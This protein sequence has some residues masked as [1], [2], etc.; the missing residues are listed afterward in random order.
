MRR[1][2]C[3]CILLVV[4]MGCGKSIGSFQD[5]SLNMEVLSNEIDNKINEGIWN[6]AP[7][8]MTKSLSEAEM[9]YGIE[10]AY[11]EE[12]LIRRSIADAAC[13]EIVI[14]HVKDNHQKDI[15]EQLQNYLQDRLTAFEKLPNQQRL[16]EQA[17]IESFGNYILFVCSKDKVNVLQYMRS[18]DA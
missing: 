2:L 11:C 4:C 7:L 15:M 13:E 10:E 12:V 17:E 6:I 5:D 3:I 1:W 16:V 9:I 8:Q 14:V 18:L